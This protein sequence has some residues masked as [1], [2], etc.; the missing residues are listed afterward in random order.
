MNS[1]SVL[2]LAL[3]FFLSFFLGC[4]RQQEALNSSDATIMSGAI[5]VGD[6]DWKDVTELDGSHPIRLNAKKVADLSL[7]A[8]ESRCT[9][10]LIGEDVL[11]TNHH[12]V[13]TAA[14]AVG[15]TANFGHETGRTGESLSFAC[16][17]FIGNN[18]EFDFA[19]LRCKGK[20]GKTLGVVTLSSQSLQTGDKIYVV[21]QNCDY[22]L[23]KKC[24]WSKKYA[25]GQIKG[26]N[27]DG[28]YKHDADTLGGSSGSP[29]FSETSNLVVALHHAGYGN[30]G[31][32]RGVENYAVPMSKVVAKL[33]SAFPVIAAQ[34]GLS[35]GTT[36]TPGNRPTYEPNN[37]TSTA[38]KISLPFTGEGL[39][40]A[41]NADKD[42][43]KFSVALKSVVSVKLQMAKALGDIDIQL[44]SSGGT[45]LYKSDSAKQ[46]ET[47]TATLNAGVYYLKVYGYQGATNDYSLNISK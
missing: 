8:I 42:W 34:I 35:G 28:D 38:A 24:D 6:V 20:P 16:D 36:P 44:Y 26:T 1:E 40:I 15:A 10:F 46:T 23:N 4:G 37:S 31:Q 41:T 5:I 2:L 43:Y 14:D 7:P 22:Y 13:T 39:S 27:S 25:R 3:L 17:E 18:E 12:C 30:N 29:V 21:Q 19:L 45:L 9:A 11:L 47:I 33:R 32:G